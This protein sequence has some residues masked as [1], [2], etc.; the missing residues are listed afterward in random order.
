[1]YTVGHDAKHTETLILGL[2]AHYIFESIHTQSFKLFFYRAGAW[3]FLQEADIILIKVL[4][5]KILFLFFIV[6]SISWWRCASHACLKLW[7][8]SLK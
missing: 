1:M 7:V 4:E 8:L 5:K 2:H 3:K 6:F